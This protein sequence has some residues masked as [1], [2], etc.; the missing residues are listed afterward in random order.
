[1]CQHKD[2]TVPWPLDFVLLG[3]GKPPKQFS[4]Q[5]INIFSLKLQVGE[6]YLM[7]ACFHGHT[8]TLHTL[9]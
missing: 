4:M 9:S 2:D 6:F 1:M 7:F 3:W 8:H 5:K